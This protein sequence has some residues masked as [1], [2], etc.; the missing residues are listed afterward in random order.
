MI[1]LGGSRYLDLVAIAAYCVV[2][3]PIGALFLLV[4]DWI[5]RK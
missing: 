1:P 3:A 2:F 4:R 5:V